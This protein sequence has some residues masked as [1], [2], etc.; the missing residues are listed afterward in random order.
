MLLLSL[1]SCIQFTIVTFQKLVL[2]G[3]FWIQDIISRPGLRQRGAQILQIGKKIW[4]T[5]A[6]VDLCVRIVLNYRWRVE[7]NKL[8][9]LIRFNKILLFNLVC[10]LNWYN[11]HYHHHYQRNPFRKIWTVIG[12]ATKGSLRSPILKDHY[13]QKIAMIKRSLISFL[14]GLVG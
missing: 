14:D 1:I 12:S 4:V 10:V 8:L 5:L 3:N 9:K 2:H 13:D 6:S 11:R 7:P